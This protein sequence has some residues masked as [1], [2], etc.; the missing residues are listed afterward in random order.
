[1][2]LS[3]VWQ[4]FRL[5]RRGGIFID[6]MFDEKK[7]A[8]AMGMSSK[9]KSHGLSFLRLFFLVIEFLLLA[10]EDLASTFF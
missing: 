7:N 3:F 4:L 9:K 6:V 2:H 1:M 5:V 8:K 10:L